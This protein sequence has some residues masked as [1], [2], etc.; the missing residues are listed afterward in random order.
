MFLLQVLV[1]QRHHADGKVP[2]DAPSRLE[3]GQ[4]R[5][6]RA[7]ERHQVRHVVSPTQ[8]HIRMKVPFR[9]TSGEDVAQRGVLPAG[10]EKREV[11]VGGGQQP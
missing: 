4:G 6:A 11:D 10:D 7:V 3:E 9:T 2:C 5:G 8:H 1:E